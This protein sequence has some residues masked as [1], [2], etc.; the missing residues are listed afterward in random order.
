MRIFTIAAA[1]AAL[2]AG[3]VLAQTSANPNAGENAAIKSPHSGGLASKG[4]NSFTQG[5]AIQHMEHAGYSDVSG[6]SQDKD[7]LWRE[8]RQDLRPV[9]GFQRQRQRRIGQGRSQFHI[10]RRDT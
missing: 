9:A 6:L 8:G 1:A 7:G 2:M 5:Q 3:P 4:A 10:H